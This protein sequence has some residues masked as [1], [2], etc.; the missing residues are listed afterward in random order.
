ME[1]SCVECPL[2]GTCNGT[3]DLTCSGESGGVPV[4]DRDTYCDINKCP[5]GKLLNYDPTPNS[6]DPCPENATCSGTRFYNCVNWSFEKDSA[7]I[8]YRT[9]CR[10]TEAGKK[11]L[12]YIN[13]DNERSCVPCPSNATCS[14]YSNFNCKRNFEKNSKGNCV[15]NRCEDETKYL[16]NGICNDCPINAE[17]NGKSE[18]SCKD[19]FEK[20]HKDNCVLAAGSATFCTNKW[21]MYDSSRAKCLPCP[22]RATCDGLTQEYECWSNSYRLTNTLG[23]YKFDGGC[24]ACPTGTQSPQGSTDI[25][26]CVLITCP[27]NHYRVGS[28]CWKCNACPGNWWTCP[29]PK[30]CSPAGSVGISA[31]HFC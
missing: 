16:D 30:S 19:G 23:G 4:Q 22:P 3:T 5:K 26:H 14:G 10:D 28:K 15:R 29:H 6:C 20:N 24:V 31:C 7:G 9:N 21:Q 17:C 18:Y 25:D 2:Y 11:Q 27:E 1:E 12:L 13:A 8:C